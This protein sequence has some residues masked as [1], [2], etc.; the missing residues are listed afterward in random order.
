[1]VKSKNFL[2]FAMS[3]TISSLGDYIYDIGIIVYLYKVTGSPLLIGSFFILQFLPSLI[4]TILAGGIADKINKKHILIFSNIVRAFV[5]IFLFLNVSPPF[6]LVSSIILG[7]CDELSRSTSHASITHLLRKEE[8]TRGNSILSALDSTTMIIG[9]IIAGLLISIAGIR[10]SILINL[11]SF[12]LSATMMI[13]IKFN[14]NPVSENKNHPKFV[15]EVKEGLLFINKSSL[16]KRILLVWGLLMMGVG[17]SGSLIIILI[18]DY[19][20]LNSSTYGW[21]GAAQGI[22]IFCGSL[23]IMKKNN[24]IPHPVLIKQGLLFIG[25]GILFISFIDNFLLLLVSY[26]AIG[27]GS[28]CAPIGI[29]SFLQVNIPNNFLGRVFLTVRFIVTSLRTMTIA[30][31]SIL[32]EFVNL[33]AIFF[34]AAAFIILA[35]LISQSLSRIHCKPNPK[36]VNYVD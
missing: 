11:I 19:M 6:I 31:A 7:I 1:M 22:G 20:N 35:S 13:I 26:V 28:A 34:A 17:I 18:T 9:P 30:T 10:G 21:I 3:N 16:V 36:L 32:A 24:N 8:I 23:I 27:I 33:R 4:F 5:L 2:F 14:I 12:L 25:L 29:R 15:Q